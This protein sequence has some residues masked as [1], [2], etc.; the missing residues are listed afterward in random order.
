MSRLFEAAKLF[1]PRMLYSGTAAAE[2]LELLAAW[3]E[4]SGAPRKVP[5]MAGIPDWIAR[6]DN[7]ALR[8]LVQRLKK[9]RDAYESQLNMLK[10]A[11]AISVSWTVPR[12]DR[13][14]EPSLPTQA[15][16]LTP[17]EIEA[18]EHSVSEA[19]L[20]REGWAEGQLGEI[21]S[22]RGRLVYRPG[23]ARAIRKVLAFVRRPDVRP[24]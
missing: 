1:H 19:L 14:A 3:Q 2:Y 10:S 9:E 15:L 18:L 16:Y 23:Y 11:T 21:T 20:E 12:P 13:A 4:H 8:Q 5:A 17:S 24:G 7:A 6:I 22:N